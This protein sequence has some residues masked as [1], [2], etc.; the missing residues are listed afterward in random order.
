MNLHTNSLVKNNIIHNLKSEG[1]NIFGMKFTGEC[2]NISVFNNII[3]D[4]V[5]SSWGT[6]DYS[7]YGIYIDGGKNFKIYHNSINLFGDF[8][9]NY[10]SDEFSCSFGFNSSNSSGNDIRD[11]IFVNTMK[12]N[13]TSVQTIT[14]IYAIGMVMDTTTKIDFND[15]YVDDSLQNIGKD[16]SGNLNLFRLPEWQ[17]FT[18]QDTS[19]KD[20]NPMFVSNTV[21]GIM[22]GSPAADS[23]QY[24]PSVPTDILGTCAPQQLRQSALMKEQMISRVQ[25]SLIQNSQTMRV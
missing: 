17:A 2:N 21:L 22:I 7:P 8:P 14:K 16:F 11:N 20:G 18:L 10:Y 6:T 5:S 15:Y 23:G 3:Y 24:I 1:G 9:Q 19:S 4:C 25:V 12:Q 13:I